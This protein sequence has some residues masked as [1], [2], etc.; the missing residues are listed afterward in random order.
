MAGADLAQ[1]GLSPGTWYKD[2]YA[3]FEFASCIGCSIDP[4]LDTRG[5]KKVAKYFN[6]HVIG[7][8]HDRV[9]YYPFTLTSSTPPAYIPKHPSFCQYHYAS[10]PREPGR[11]I[12]ELE[13]EIQQA[14]A[15]LTGTGRSSIVDLLYELRLW[16]NYTGVQSLLKLSDGGYQRFLVKNLGTIIYFIGGLAEIVTMAALGEVKYLGILKRFS[17][18]Y[19]DKHER[20]ARNKFLIPPYIR[21]RSYKHLGLIAGPI[22]FIVPE[23]ADPVQFI[24][25]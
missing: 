13:D 17:R 21:L 23:S 1:V 3:V 11:G 24:T 22:D 15:A 16:A 19:I 9:L 18:D 4:S 25:L 7:S 6:N 5:H 8:T 20:F 2:Y 10:Y 12:G 14:F